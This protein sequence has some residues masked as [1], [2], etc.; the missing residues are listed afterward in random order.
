VQIRDGC[1]SHLLII[2]SLSMAGAFACRTA[3]GS[4]DSARRSTPVPNGRTAFWRTHDR[5]RLVRLHGG[6]DHGLAQIKKAP[7]VT[8][9]QDPDEAEVPSMPLNAMRQVGVDHV[10]PADEMA[11]AIVGLL[12]NP[13]K[14]Q[15]RKSPRRGSA[16]TENPN[17]E[18]P[19]TDALRTGELRGARPRAGTASR[20]ARI[21]GR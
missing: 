19:G 12:M 8:L 20:G 13:R 6:R 18:E 7:G 3:R 14:G 10:L 16:K 21:H 15:T 9:V 1:A 2:T 17:A 4:T 11:R 5:H